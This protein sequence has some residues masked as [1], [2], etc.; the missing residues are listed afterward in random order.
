MSNE[1]A[2]ASGSPGKVH[3]TEEPLIV[4]ATLPT[5]LIASS[6]SKGDAS[7]I[8]IEE[9]CPTAED[10]SSDYNALTHRQRATLLFFAS[11]AATISPASSTT[12]FPAVTSLA[13]DLQVSVSLINLTISVYQIFQGLAPSVTAAFSDRYGRRPAYIICFV[14][15]FGA[16][17]GLALQNSYTPLMVLRCLQSSGSSGTVALAQAVLDDVTTSEQ[18]GKYMAYLSIG[19]IMGPAL[20]PVIGGLLSQYLGWRGIFWFLLIFGGVL[21]VLVA[22]LFPETNRSIVGD[23]S[24]PPQR[25]NRSFL[26][27]FQKGRLAPNPMSIEKKVTG[28][29]PF[30]SLRILADRENLILCIYGGLLFAGFSATTGV[31]A[32]QLDERYHLNQVQAGLC[33]LPLG[34]GSILSRWTV[35]KLI[36]WNFKREAQRQGVII[37]K[38]R[39]QDMSIHDVEK[40]RLLIAFPM[41]LAMSGFLVAFG[42]LMQY[43]AHLAAV[44]VVGFLFANMLTGALVAT[45]ALLTDINV[46]NGASL[47]AAM[48]LVRCLMAAGGVAAITPMINRIGIGYAATLMAAIWILALPPLWLVY[49]RGY[50]W[51][52]ASL[53]AIKGGKS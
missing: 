50:Q 28:V 12:Y 40:V 9:A 6:L 47:G 1:S 29:N 25:W 39:K 53:D 49:K 32:S 11:C 23:G 38:N 8:K 44:L 21:M 36:D 19:F 15:N 14:I 42:W 33:Y 5:P 45:S 34:F 10:I 51:R 20:G 46:G 4:D 35:G 16:N 41:I 17:L 13:R 7:S 2:T 48:N 31:F 30:K 52:K 43:Q 37:V 24:N 18:R 26:Q 22:I 3:I 27:L